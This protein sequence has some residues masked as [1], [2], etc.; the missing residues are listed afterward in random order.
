M[1]DNTHIHGSQPSQRLRSVSLFRDLDRAALSRA[2]GINPSVVWRIEGSQGFLSVITLMN[3]AAALDVSAD[4]LLGMSADA[5]IPDSPP[6]RV[7]AL[8]RDIGRLSLT[9]RR[10]VTGPV[11]SLGE[12]GRRAEKQEDMTGVASSREGGQNGQGLTRARRQPDAGSP[13]RRP[14][15]SGLPCRA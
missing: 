11:A 15:E 13:A 5:R 10:I 7:D 8:D 1:S 4:Y 2:V 12:V 6:R 14:R 3:L 9:H